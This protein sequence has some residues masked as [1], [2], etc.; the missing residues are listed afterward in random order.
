MVRALL[1][2]AFL[3]FVT[4]IVRSARVGIAGDYVDPIAKITA[5]DEALYAN[6]SIHAATAGGWLTPMFMGRF[7]LYKPPMLIWAAGLSARILGVSRIALRL[8]IALLCSL[9]AGLVFLWAAELRSPLAGICAAGLLVS[10]HLWHVLGGLSMTD[11]LLVAFFTAAMYILFADP[12]LESRAALWGFAGSVA[13]AVLT[14]SVAG[15][16]PVAALGLYWMVAPRPERPRLSRAALAVVLAGALA[17]PWFVYQLL[18]HGRWFW[19]EHIQ[20][21]LLGFGAGAPP[22]TTQESQWLFYLKRLPLIDPVLTAAALVAIPAFALALRKRSASATLL[23]CWMAAVI[24]AVLAFQ[25]RNVAYLLPLMP[26]LAVLA[27]GYGPKGWDAAL[28]VL[29]AGAFVLKAAMPVQPWGVSFEAGTIQKM[30]PA[31]RNYCERRRGNELILVGMEDDLVASTLPLARLRYCL[32][33]APPADTR[34]GMKFREMGIILSSDEFNYLERAR[35]MFRDRLREW[36]L[37]SDQPI[38]TLVMAPSMSDLA[39]MVRAH[40]ADDFV[41]PDSYGPSVLPDAAHEREDAAGYFFLLSKVAKPRG[42]PP[43]WP[44]EM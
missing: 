7:A 5:Q 20:V 11:G 3:A 29:V 4:L 35:P 10:N 24:A 25:Y 36:G 42:D 31:L 33:A 16:I 37:D 28:A 14:K 18:V 17:A 9:S 15:V 44:C 23:L 43:H 26:A 27:G 40:P 38:G 6:S 19:A 34:Y 1:A 30:A 32:L 39:A 2:I 12:W 13:A 8:P 41:L 22:Q 21:E